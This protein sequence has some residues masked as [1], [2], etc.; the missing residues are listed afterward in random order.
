[1]LELAQNNIRKQISDIDQ[2]PFDWED[3]TQLLQLLSHLGI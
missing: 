2:T 3:C 1:M